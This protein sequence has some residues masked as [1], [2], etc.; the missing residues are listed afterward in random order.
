MLEHIS[1]HSIAS[2][3][4]LF[5]F[6]KMLAYICYLQ[7]EVGTTCPTGILVFQNLSNLIFNIVDY[8]CISFFLSTLFL[9]TSQSDHIVVL[10]LLCKHID[11]IQNISRILTKELSNF[12]RRKVEHNVMR[13]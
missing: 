3:T 12:H 10:V 2:F 6:S 9:L 11:I 5:F 4:N 1:P 13:L 7:A 8:I